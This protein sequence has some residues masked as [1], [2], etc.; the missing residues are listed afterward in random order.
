MYSL[1]R[2]VAALTERVRKLEDTIAVGQL[3]ATY[4]PA[5]DSGMGAVAANL[6]AVD[7]EYDAQVGVWRG[8]EEIMGMIAGETHQGFL[9]R[10][11]AHVNSAPIIS[12]DG[13]AALAT[14]YGFMF[15]CG[16][17][18]NIFVFRLTTSRWEWRR[19]D[20]SWELIR[21]TNRL[22]DGHNAAREL[23]RMAVQDRP[24][25]DAAPVEPE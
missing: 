22:V 20:G 1:K 13:D 23:L 12:V 19:R 14:A 3:V 2:R 21:R 4:G 16:E 11:C 17:D 6:W 10:G 15:S 5:V 9:R 18:G 25:G 24:G 8:R 7:G